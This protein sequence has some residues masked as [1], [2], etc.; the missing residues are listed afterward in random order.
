MIN[1][2]VSTLYHPLSFSCPHNRPL[3]LLKVRSNIFNT[4]DNV[5]QR[6][7]VR[8]TKSKQFKL[9]VR[10]NFKDTEE[11]RQ[12]VL[13]N[14]VYMSWSDEIPPPFRYRKTTKYE[15]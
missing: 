5:Q 3:P 4:L 10:S 15:I 6:E 7:D 2:D 12:D 8:N 9:S 14:S 11:R 13:G 1:Q